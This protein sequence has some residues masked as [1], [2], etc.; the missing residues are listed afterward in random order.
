MLVMEQL[1]ADWSAPAFCDVTLYTVWL[2]IRTYYQTY[3]NIYTCRN[4]AKARENLHIH[5]SQQVEDCNGSTNRGKLLTLH[6]ARKRT[7]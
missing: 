7:S 1:V 3:C 2:C 5:F 4:D 6:A